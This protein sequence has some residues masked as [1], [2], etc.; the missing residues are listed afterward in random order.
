MTPYLF[1]EVEDMDSVRVY[2][3][4]TSPDEKERVEG[5]LKG[6]KDVKKITSDLSVYRGSA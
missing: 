6:I 5:I 1:V 3:M 4:I 2:G